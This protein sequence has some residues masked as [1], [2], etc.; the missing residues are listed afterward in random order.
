MVD[1]E[2]LNQLAKDCGFTTSRPLDISKLNFLQEVRD[3][4]AAN[5]CHNF[6]KSWSCPPACPSLEEM[7]EKIKAYSTGII[8]QTVGELE[9]NLDWDAMQEAGVKQ[10]ESFQKMWAV[11]KND[12][13][14]LF[15]MGAGGCRICETCTYPDN[16]CRF[17]EL[18]SYS[19]EACGLVISQVC[20]DNAIPYNYGPNAISYTGC[21]LLE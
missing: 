1:F 6:D 14:N 8:V 17:P 13:P 21:F 11:L 4:C 2:T 19:M 7:R 9:D 12:Y 18:L 16:P 15:P 5:T 3:M 10:Q 20:T